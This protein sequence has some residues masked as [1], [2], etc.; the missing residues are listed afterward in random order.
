MEN[1]YRL[2]YL[3]YKEKYFSLKNGLGIN[4]S[5]GAGF[6]S[7]ALIAHSSQQNDRLA[8]QKKKK[9]QDE[10]KKQQDEL[11]KK[12]DEFD[13][14]PEEEKKIFLEK[15]QRE[16]NDTECID[17]QKRKEKE[18]R[19]RKNN[20]LIV[21][22]EKK[23]LLDKYNVCK[24]KSCGFMG[25]R[26]FSSFIDEVN[27]II[28]AKYDKTSVQDILKNDPQIKEWKKDIFTKRSECKC[29]VL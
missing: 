18:E 19:I 27:N 17:R 5:N 29:L 7:G 23:Q 21:E 20:E 12:Q 1:L 24:E 16:K 2:N 14:L 28:L 10:L 13:A 4:V 6:G 25:C 15:K 3:K 11:K 22:K 26:N 8:R 9:Q